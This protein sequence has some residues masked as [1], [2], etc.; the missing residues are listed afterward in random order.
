MNM[1]EI[2]EASL[3]DLIIVLVLLT[4]GKNIK[5]ANIT[6]GKK[7]CEE[8]ERRGVVENGE[9]FFEKWMKAYEL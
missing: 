6:Q 8:F 5:K 4:Q 2:R 9:Q 3:E 7:I 1:K